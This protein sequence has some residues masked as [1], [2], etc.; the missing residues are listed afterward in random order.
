MEIRPGEDNSAE[1]VRFVAGQAFRHAV[2]AALSDR[3]QARV[4]DRS[5]QSGMRV[6]LRSIPAYR[7]SL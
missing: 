5:S 4:L 1:Q 2:R 7:R 3:L 6:V